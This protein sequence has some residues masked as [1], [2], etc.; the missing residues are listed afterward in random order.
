[1]PAWFWQVST[2][3]LCGRRKQKALILN[4]AM[5]GQKVNSEQQAFAKGGSLNISNFHLPH[6]EGMEGK[7]K[8]PHTFN[9][10]CT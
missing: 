1:M 2:N 10:L 7:S 4:V 6:A 5:F 8:S 3:V 9:Q